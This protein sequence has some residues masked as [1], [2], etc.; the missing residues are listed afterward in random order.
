M[1]S[2]FTYRNRNLE[3]RPGLIICL[4]EAKS[5]SRVNALTALIRLDA[6]RKRGRMVMPANSAQLY[7]P[8]LEFKNH[9][10]PDCQFTLTWMDLCFPSLILAMNAH[11]LSRQIKN[12]RLINAEFGDFF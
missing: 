11:F 9:G 3:V 7:S 1:S 5:F 6:V 2:V 12:K 8:H 4:R 10:R